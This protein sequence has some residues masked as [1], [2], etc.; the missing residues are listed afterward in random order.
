MRC[1]FYRL[2]INYRQIDKQTKKTQTNRQTD[3]EA[4]NRCAYGQT[5]SMELALQTA[6][7]ENSHGIAGHNTP[8][9]K[10]IRHT[11]SAVLRIYI[12]INI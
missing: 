8:L 12:Q 10:Q 5:R 11:Y 6:Y 2:T 1:S 4:Y 9:S 3:G 7:H